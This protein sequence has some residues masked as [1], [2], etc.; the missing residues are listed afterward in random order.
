[1]TISQRG[2]VHGVPATS[3]A[4]AASTTS[5][6]SAA[7]AGASCCASR[8]TRRTASTRSTRRRGSR[9]TGDARRAS[10]KATAT[11]RTSRRRS[12]T[13]SSATCRA[14][15]PGG[16]GAVRARRAPGSPA[17]QRP[18]ETRP[19]ARTGIQRRSSG[20]F[21]SRGTWQLRSDSNQVTGD[22]G[23]NPRARR[24]HQPLAAPTLSPTCKA[25]GPK[26]NSGPAPMLIQI[27]AD[28]G[29]RSRVERVACV[30]WLAIGSR[31]LETHDAKARDCSRGRTGPVRRC[32]KRSRQRGT[33]GQ[34]RPGHE[35]D[36]GPAGAREGARGAEG[37]GR[38]LRRRGGGGAP[39]PRRR[40]R[41]ARAPKRVPRM[42]TR[43]ASR[44]TARRCSTR[45][46]TSS[47]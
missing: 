47:A 33:Q 32:A 19:R 4:P 35:D 2:D 13:R 9:S 15:G 42:P 10:P 37:Q 25:I 31:T 12:A 30:R 7:G 38:T 45:S 8:S 43:P 40:W 23:L 5:S 20:R 44:S 34:A 46:T 16:G 41:R 17:P 29:P 24:A 1:M 3:S 39:A 36:P 18:P 26:C 11:S 21:A 27:N 28:R 14:H 6:R 22:T